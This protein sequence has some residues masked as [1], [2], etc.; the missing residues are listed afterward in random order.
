MAVNFFNQF[1]GIKLKAVAKAFEKN[2]FDVTICSSKVEALD[3]MLGIVESAFPGVVA[4]G[5]S[6]TVRGTGIL[7]R[8]A[9]MDGITFLDGFDSS[10]SRP[11]RM[12]IRRKALSADLFFSGVN[13]ITAKGELVWLDMI[14]NRIA[15]IAFGPS[16]VVI[17]AGKNKI[18]ASLSEAMERVKSYAA[19][20]NA[21]KH[22]D[23]KTPCQTT[24]TCHD[25]SSPHRICNSWLIM[26]KSF[27]VGRV[28][29][30]LIDEEL[31]L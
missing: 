3:A 18:T 19:P 24:A 8:V 25:C 29:L 4:Y 6:M 16:T 2:G 10:M 23:F 14:G 31:G 20:L 15:P 17:V 11:E 1:W 9:Q 26:E 13:A 12:E 22:T 28:K 30:I 21:I 7:D 5:D 27:P